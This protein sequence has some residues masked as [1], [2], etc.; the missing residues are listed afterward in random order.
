M[1][2]IWR[3]CPVMPT[4]YFTLAKIINHS[5]RIKVDE[6]IMLLPWNLSSLINIKMRN[7]YRY[8]LISVILITLTAPQISLK[9]IVYVLYGSY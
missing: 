3:A 7:E 1:G 8:G 5:S 4:S 2:Y 6:T 9:E